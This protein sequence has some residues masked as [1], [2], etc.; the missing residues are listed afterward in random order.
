MSFNHYFK[1]IINKINDATEYTFRTELENL[2][3]FAKPDNGIKIQQEPRKKDFGRPDFKI[4]KNE[5]LL[6]YIETK[7]INDELS[8]YIETNQLRRYLTVIKN[9]ILTNYRDFILFRDGEKILEAKLF[10]LGDK[11]LK[12]H[13]I[14]A[15]QGLLKIFF[16]YPVEPI[17]NPKD[18]AQALAA[19]TRLLR[20]F[21]DETFKSKENSDFKSKLE[22]LNQLF[23]N[24]LISDLSIEEFIDEYSQ[25]LTYGLLTA[26]L[27]KNPQ[28]KLEKSNIKSFFPASI[29]LIK[30]I[31]SPL[32][33]NDIPESASWIISEIIDIL[34]QID[35]KELKNQLAF[36]NSK[37]DDPY[38]YFYEDFLAAYDENKRKAKG[39][40]YTPI[41]VVH[42][43][44][45]SIEKILQ[46]DFKK[47]GLIDKDVKILD[48]ATGTG[49][50]LLEAMKLGLES[51][52]PPLQ[53]KAIKERIL[54]NFY[55]FEYMIAPY[56]IAHLKLSNYIKNIGYTFKSNERVQ[57]YLTDTLDDSK[58]TTQSLFPQLSKEGEVSNNIKLSVPVLVIMGNPPYNNHSRNKKPFILELIKEYKKELN[59]KKINLDDDYIKFIRYAQCKIIGQKY[60]YKNKK[61][62]QLI[63]GEIVGSGKGIIGI[64]T[65]NS[66]LDGLSHRKMRESLFNSFDKIYILN[67]HGNS[68]KGEP[69]ENVFDIKIGVAIALFIKLE[70]PLPESEKE[71]NYFSTLDNGLMKRNEKYDFLLNNDIETI[72]WKK[73]KPSSPFYWFIDKDLSSKKEYGQGWSL[74][75]IFK[76]YNSG[77]ETGKDHLV[78]DF[79][80]NTLFKRVEVVLTGTDENEIRKKYDLK[81]TSGW[82]L[83]RF[84]K[85][86]LKEEKIIPYFYRPFDIRWIFYDNYALKRDRYSIMRHF[87]KKNN[88]G[89]SFTR[90]WEMKTNWS[91]AF[92]SDGIIDRHY[93]GGQSYFAPLYLTD[94]ENTQNNFFGT[95]KQEI[96][97]NFSEKFKEFLKKLYHESFTSQEI[98]GYIYAVLH[99]PRYREIYKEFFRHDF[100]RII[101]VSDYKKF[102][103]LSKIGNELINHHL[104]KVQYEDLPNYYGSGNAKVEKIKYGKN[105][106]FINK[107]DYFEPVSKEVYEFE[108]GGYKV[109]EKYLNYRKGRILTLDEIEHIKKVIKAI[110]YTL[111]LMQK[112]DE[113]L[114]E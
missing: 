63:E 75:E 45:K 97:D 78:I 21:L 73:F 110:E 18:L 62:K 29:P 101:F 13:N 104:L 33:L 70:N 15:V 2:L 91:G 36:K 71:I 22:G 82:T 14:E 76:E 95:N 31:F 98:F 85:A 80:K 111:K 53:V 52:D 109:I 47:E 38:I 96:A 24:T 60:S 94:F 112:I 40:Y 42:F 8:K 49:T 35:V 64:I 57:V 105:K 113:I 5:G 39:V 93:V 10:D 50:F 6:G 92:I 89:L 66:Y 19:R 46:N 79:E 74:V 114:W 11:K 59:E 67:L 108:I 30:E 83:K 48:F 100:P 58:H 43:I 87:L 69:D 86:E 23:K 51:I 107:T 16:E 26:A 102:K 12:K 56:T 90:S 27:S 72:A 37:R 103:E 4:L 9:L 54:N 34:N 61:N 84:K 99:S 77:I 17:K 28:E 32:D 7:P 20:D 55:G 65:N 88:I 41:P 68:N 44:V 81:D 25:T 106:F 1:Q 3:N